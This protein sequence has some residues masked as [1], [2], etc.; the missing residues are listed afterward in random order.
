M[1]QLKTQQLTQTNTKTQEPKISAFNQNETRLALAQ[2]QLE[3]LREK[4]RGLE[5]EKR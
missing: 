4:C 3:E 1:Q 2:T 5:R